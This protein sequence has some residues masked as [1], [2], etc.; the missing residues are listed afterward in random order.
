ME[1]WQVDIETHSR[2]D[3]MKVC[4]LLAKGIGKETVANRRVSVTVYDD[5]LNVFDKATG[6]LKSPAAGKSAVTD[7]LAAAFSDDHDCYNL[8][9]SALIEEWPNQILFERVAQTFKINGENAVVTLQSSG[10][11]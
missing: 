8:P 5:V 7:G 1:N 2:E 11:K 10:G 9:E 3:V 6:Q 4:A